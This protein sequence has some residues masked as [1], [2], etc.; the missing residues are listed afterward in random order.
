MTGPDAATGQMAEG[1]REILSEPGWREASP[2][3]LRPGELGWVSRGTGNAPHADVVV[4]RWLD[5]EVSY[6]VSAIWVRR[7]D[8]PYWDRAVALGKRIERALAGSGG[9]EAE[10]ER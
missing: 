4:R 5:G 3:T 7:A 8:D 6:Y 2:E 9:A 10:G 1:L